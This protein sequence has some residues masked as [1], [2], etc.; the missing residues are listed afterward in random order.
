M[1]HSGHSGHCATLRLL[2]RASV[3]WSCSGLVKWCMLCIQ[4]GIAE[5]Y[6]RKVCVCVCVCVC[7]NASTG[8]WWASET[9]HQVWVWL[10][11]RSRRPITSLLNFFFPYF[12][13]ERR[14]RDIK[15][16]NYTHTYTCTHTQ[17]K[18]SLSLSQICC[19]NFIN[20]SWISFSVVSACKYTA[21]PH[22][23]FSVQPLDISQRF[24]K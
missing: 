23:I 19:C 5:M 13:K 17:W 9:Q 8:W 22:C 11:E 2:Y 1:G 21:C 12:F 14:W 15:W 20:A 10:S 6:S 3:V 4:P 7:Q 16:F 18:L 24:L